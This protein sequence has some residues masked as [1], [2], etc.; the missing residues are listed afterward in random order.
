MTGNLR[1]AKAR[2]RP[3]DPMRA[4]DALPAPLRQ[5]AAQAVLP[6]SARS[7]RRAWTRALRAT[8]CPRAALLRLSA[9]EAAT[10][11]S[12]GPRIWGRGHPYFSALPE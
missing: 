4:H 7:L 1:S 2:T 12:E 3:G 9:A 10:L 5:W 11:A 8:G 6:W